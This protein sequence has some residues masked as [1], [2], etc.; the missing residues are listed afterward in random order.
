MTVCYSHLVQTALF[1]RTF[2]LDKGPS[3]LFSISLNHESAHYM[4]KKQYGLMP[5]NR[6]F[7]YIFTLYKIT[8]LFSNL[9]RIIC[10]LQYS[11]A[12]RTSWKILTTIL[13]FMEKIAGNTWPQKLTRHLVFLC[14]FLILFLI[15]CMYLFVLMSILCF[16][17][18]I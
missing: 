4:I 3:H 8:K 17:L 12:N 6:K 7:V 5:G 16:F 13:F 15:K 9:W 18:G 10:S 1:F 2:A 14:L 11:L